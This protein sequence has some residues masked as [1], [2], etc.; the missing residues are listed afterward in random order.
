[1][2]LSS[3]CSADRSDHLG[4]TYDGLFYRPAVLTGAGPGTPAYDNEAF[5]PVAPV[6][7]FATPG[8]AV[9]LAADSEYGLDLSIMTAGIG[10]GLQMALRIPTGT[11]H[12]ND[13]TVQDEANA[14]FG[15]MR[16]PGNSA[17]FG[18]AAVAT[19]A[20]TPGGRRV[21]TLSAKTP[22][23][24]PGVAGGSCGAGGRRDNRDPL[25]GCPVQGGQQVMTADQPRFCP[26]R[27]A[28]WPSG[29]APC[30]CSHRPR[31][32]ANRTRPANH[33]RSVKKSFYSERAVVHD[34]SLGI[35]EPP[36]RPAGVGIGRP[37]PGTP[38]CSSSSSVSAEGW[39]RSWRGHPAAGS[40]RGTGRLPGCARRR[41]ACGR[42]TP[43]VT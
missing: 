13:Q 31:A 32:G 9:D 1:M 19:I 29:P 12:I 27:R 3:G 25:L 17:R 26:A 42:S 23:H 16:H 11:A 18:G 6:I 41:R 33:G 8:E 21:S 7:S 14:P 36:C 38:L 35:T 40:A 30:A 5:G 20:R 39:P 43:L 2:T 24:E 22:P 10:A 4:S 37:R 15:G 34:P 28:A